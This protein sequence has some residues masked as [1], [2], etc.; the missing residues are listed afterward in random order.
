MTAHELLLFLTSSGLT[1]TQIAEESGVFQPVISRI[2]TGKQKD[3]SFKDGKKIE[4]LYHKRVAF[5]NSQA[6]AK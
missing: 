2:V 6:D 3:L 4:A 5:L 1:Q